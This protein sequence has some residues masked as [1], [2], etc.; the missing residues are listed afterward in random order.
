M[1]TAT[2]AV[3]L[4]CY[5]LPPI[6]FFENFAEDVPVLLNC[7]ATYL[8]GTYCNRCIIATANGP[9]TLS[10]PLRSGKYLQSF[11]KIK[12][13]YDE[14]WQRQHWRSI[15]D[16]Y[17]NAPFFLHYADLLEPVFSNRYETL[18]EWNFALLRLICHFLHLPPPI[19]IFEREPAGIDKAA[20]L[21]AKTACTFKTWRPTMPAEGFPKYVQ[22]FEDRNGFLPNLSILDL[23]FCTGPEAALLLQKLRKASPHP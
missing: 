19:C 5:Y 14:S 10:V 3:L 16:A 2:N 13:A 21:R 7:G 6:R 18:L 23:I 22:V 15:R 11:D 8:K 12:I 4:D 20:T 17:R 1:V 9:L